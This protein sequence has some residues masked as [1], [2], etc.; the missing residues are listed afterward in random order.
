MRLS[1]GAGFRPPASRAHPLPGVA[2]G[3][4]IPAWLAHPRAATRLA[5]HRAHQRP[6]LEQLG[7]LD[8]H[9]IEMG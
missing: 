5:H 6:E 2:I 9:L 3:V 4:R 1:A 8:P 7:L